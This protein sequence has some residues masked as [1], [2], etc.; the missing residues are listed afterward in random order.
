MAS[1]L[2]NTARKLEELYLG[3]IESPK[4]LDVA[5]NDGTLLSGYS[6]NVVKIGVDPLISNFKNNYPANSILLE[7]YFGVQ[8][9]NRIEY[10]SID[11]ATSMSVLY[12]L[13]NP[14]EFAKEIWLTL[15]PGGIWYFEQSYLPT[16]LEN[17]GY[18]TICH[19]HLLYLSAKDIE[20][21]C[22]VAGFHIEGFELNSVNGG[23]IAVTARKIELGLNG[24][25]HQKSLIED[26]IELEEQKGIVSGKALVEFETKVL[27]H[28]D[29]LR[30]LLLSKKGEGYKVYALGASTKG[31]VLLQYSSIDK[32]LI[33]AIG[34]INPKKVGKVTP[35]TGIPII[36]QEDVFD[37]IREGKSVLVILPWHFKESVLRQLQNHA[38]SDL[39]IIIPLPT[40][41]LL[42]FPEVF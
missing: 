33:V 1:H 28:R 4:V 5:S 29:N 9:R 18:D 15:A 21:I 35:S 22:R 25:P 14:I 40:L 31:N 38:Y 20:G 17:C 30:E 11:I 8:G 36:S 27:E 13:E 32:N 7:D 41:E 42:S 6:D 2:K 16:M 19:E 34:E 26:L 10:S 23:S 12:D 3:S 24:P 39:E 37:E